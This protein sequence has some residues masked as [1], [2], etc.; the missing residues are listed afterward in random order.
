VSASHLPGTAPALDPIV[1]P[2]ISALIDVPGVAAIALGGSRARGTAAAT[3]DYDIGLYYREG[4]EPRAV[5]IREATRGLIDNPE[6]ATITEV[7]DWGRW[8]VG[9]AWLRVGGMKVDLL[10]RCTDAVRRV[11]CDCRVGRVTMDYQPGHPHGF[12]SAIWMGEVAL[13]RPLHDPERLLANLKAKTAPYP[14]PL[15]ETLV[16]RFQWEAQFSIE[17]AEAALGREDDTYV[18]GCAFRALSCVAQA[19]FALNRRYLIN[20]KGAIGEASG[21]PITISRL[22]DRASEVWRA[23]GRQAL[24]EAIDALRVIE[25]ELRIVSAE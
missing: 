13:C 17:N 3:S 22:T 19:L 11:V 16:R 12:S 18:A 25:Q 15:R 24:A 5:D 6:R 23:I 2:L 14:E 9:G 21:L 4:A 1:R 8:I 10:Y 20:E 7:G